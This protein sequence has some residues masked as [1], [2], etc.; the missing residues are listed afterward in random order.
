LIQARNAAP[1]GPGRPPVRPDEFAIALRQIVANT[2]PL[3]YRDLPQFF[4]RT[5]FTRALKEDAG[6]VL[7]HLSGKTEK[8]TRYPVAVARPIA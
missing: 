1:R 7:R 2:A 4:S 5:C 6:M 3:N 8:A